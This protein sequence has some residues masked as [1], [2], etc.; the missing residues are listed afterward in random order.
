[1]VDWTYLAEVTDKREGCFPVADLTPGLRIVFLGTGKSY[2]SAQLVASL[3]R[4]VRLPAFA[5]DATHCLH[6]DGGAF[7]R[8]V[9]VI[10]ISRSGKTVET[11]AAARQ[12]ILFGAQL[13]SVTC[14]ESTLFHLADRRVILPCERELYLN[15]PSYSLLA[16]QAY[17]LEWGLEIA[18]VRDI[19]QEIKAAH[20]G[21]V[22]Y[23]G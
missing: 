18:K 5:L 11:I 9:L 3:W 16:I 15:V 13:W 7:G 2:L 17:L 20:P 23:Q 12:A 14:Q 21:G 10:A 8:D 19:E 1:L 22:L 4:S 6:G